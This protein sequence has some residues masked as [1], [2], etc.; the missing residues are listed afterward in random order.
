MTEWTF[1][2]LMTNDDSHDGRVIFTS[3]DEAEEARLT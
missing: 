2:S 1:D 3:T